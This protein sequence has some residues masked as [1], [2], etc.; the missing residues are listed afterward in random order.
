VLAL[1]F[2]VTP[3]RKVPKDKLLRLCEIENIPAKSDSPFDLAVEQMKLRL[4]GG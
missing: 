4:G 2:S 1:L 3:E